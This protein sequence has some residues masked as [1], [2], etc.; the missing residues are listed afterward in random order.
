MMHQSA[1]SAEPDAFDNKANYILMPSLFEKY[2]IDPEIVYGLL[3][4]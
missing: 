2:G 3:G 1:Y 4:E